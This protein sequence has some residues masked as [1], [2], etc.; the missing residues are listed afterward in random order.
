MS[1][2][3]HQLRLDAQPVPPLRPGGVQRDFLKDLLRVVAAVQ[4]IITKR[5]LPSLQKE[6]DEQRGLLGLR[7]DAPLDQVGV[8]I[9]EMQLEFAQR[10]SEGEVQQITAKAAA[11]GSDVN[12]VQVQNQLRAVG[13]DLF[14]D[15]PMLTDVMRDFNRANVKLI[16]SLASTTFSRVEDVV[17]RGFRSGLRHTEIA[18][19]I[20][21]EFKTTKNRAKLIARDQV[22]K[23]NSQLSRQRFKA[24]GITK[25][26]WRT[27]GDER[28]RE[29]HEN[30][31]GQEFSLE[32]GLDGEFPGDPINCRCF[33]EPVLPG[34]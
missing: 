22:C 19:D 16:K 8:T 31:N 20:Q 30:R 9:N 34:G 17:E 12:R 11:R 25:A 10:F 29:E 21:R 1:H 18:K 2:P 7:T 15:T 26:I 33:S 4:E 13:F 14:K 6:A 3:A 32:T 23:L 5:L 28:V 27:M 24:N